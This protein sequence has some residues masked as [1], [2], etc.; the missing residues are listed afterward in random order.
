VVEDL[1]ALSNDEIVKRIQA[2][3]A[4]LPGTSGEEH[5][6]L[7][8]EILELEAEYKRRGLVNPEPHSD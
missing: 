2:A 5:Q 4:E 7:W 8:D 3:K 6:L 1:R